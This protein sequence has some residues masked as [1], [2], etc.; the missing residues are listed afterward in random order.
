MSCKLIYKGQEFD[1]P[2]Q[3]LDYAQE[4]R[5]EE[6]TSVLPLPL[7]V[8]DD[9]YLQKE[10]QA[11]M[12]TDKEI[13]QKIE[14]F[15][16]KIGVSV[17]SVREIRDSEGKRINAIAKAD[18]LH[19][20]IEV[21]EDRADITTLPEEAAH[22]FVEMLGQDHPLLKEMMGKITGY[23]LYPDIVAQYK[24]QK[25]YRNDDG[26][27]NFDKLKK[28]AIGKL[29]AQHIIQQERGSETETKLTTAMTWFHKL[30][31]FLKN[32]FSKAKVQDN[33][34]NEIAEKIRTQ[35][36]EDL[37]TSNLKQEGEFYQLDQS[38]EKLNTDQSRIHLDNSIDPVSGQKRH[39]YTYDGVQAKGSV[40]S[41]Y[42]DAWSKKRFRSDNRSEQQKLIDL[43]KAEYGDVIHAEM[44]NIVKSWTNEDGTLRD[45]QAPHAVLS[46]KE[47]YDK[48]SRF[49]LELMN[50]YP[51][52]TI[53]KSETKV[54][55]KKTR[56][57]GSID[58][59][60]IQPDGKV[61]MYDWKSQE[62]SKGQ[63]DLKHY[64]TEM[65][66]I[67]LENY[68]KIL[69]L[70]YGFKD[71]GKIR[72]IP[73]RTAFIYDKGQ[74]AG[75]KEIEIG[76]VDPSLIPED[77]NYL[78]PVT[79]KNESTG[80]EEVDEMIEK[81]H[82]IYDKIA[83]HRYSKDE[84]YKKREEMAKLGS[85]IRDLQLRGTVDK[86]VELGLIEFNKYNEK[87]KS[88]TLTGKDIMEAEKILQVFNDS[89]TYLYDMMQE[90]H[91]SAKESEEPGA[92]QAYEDL[93][94]KFLSMTARTG[95]LISD[96]AK[97]RD[98]E[99]QKLA[100]SNGI[101]NLLDAEKPVGPI[102]GLFAALSKIT[103][104]S[105]RTF[106]K[107]LQRVQ[108]T[109]DAKFD[110]MGEELSGLKKTMEDWAA[111]KGIS[112]SKA[113][114]MMLNTKDGNWNGNF[115]SVYRSEFYKQKEQAIKK[116][117]VD[118]MIKNLVFDD[119]RYEEQEKK[120]L[121]FLKSMQYH[122]DEQKNEETIK[123]KFA[124]WKLYNN[125]VDPKGGINQV[126]LL[127]PANKFLKPKEDW[128]TDQWRELQKPENKPVKDVYDY[129]Q[130]MTRY[131]EGLGMLDEYSPGFIPSIGATKIDQL[132]FGD[133]KDL[134]STKGL[135]ENLEVDSGTKYTPEI[136]PT[137]G[138]VINRI[139]VYF[140]RDMGVEQED[141]TYDY[142]KKS[143]DLFKVFGI[144]GAHMYNYEA[145]QNI[146]DAAMV[147]LEAER[148]KKSLVTDRF[149]NVIM[150]NGKVKAA[151]NNDRNARLL[152][153]FVNFY[154]Y[155]KVNGLG[156]D[157]KFKVPFSDKEYSLTKTV[158]KAIH[159]FSFKTLALNPISGT[160]Q[161]VGGTGN[162]LFMA[163]KG[164]FFTS[165]DWAKAMYQYS[166]RDKK[167][168]AA[169]HWFNPHLEGNQRH[170]IDG[171][172]ISSGNRILS[173][174]KA[175]FIQ[176]KADEAVQNPVAIAMMNNHMIEDGKIV[177]ITQYVKS[178]YNYN[179]T[180]YRMSAQERKDIQQKI[181]KEVGELKETRSLLKVG[182][183]DDHG[184]FSLPGI[185]KDSEA[186]SEFRNKIKGV[187]KKIIGNV[188]RDDINH[189]R[190][191]M[192]GMS[193]MQFRN[194]IPDMVEERLAGLK[195][196]DSLGT[197]TYG[198]MNLFFSEVFSKRFPAL[199][200]S[201]ITGFG[202]DAIK[203]ALQKYEELKRSA[204]EKGEDFNIS[205]GEFIDM[206][207]GNIRSQ[208]LELMTV[209]GFTAGVLAMAGGGGSSND[210]LKG[211]KKYAKRA[212]AK[213]YNEFAFYYNPLEF[214]N[215]VKSPLPVVGLAEDFYRFSG[216][217]AKQ[218]YG[219]A[220][221]NDKMMKSAQPSKYFFRMFPVTKEAML[222]MAAYDDQFRKDWNIKLD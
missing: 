24:G 47:T 129:F 155:D 35:N 159:F 205:E 161:F 51:P 49:V 211:A 145:M 26:T 57:A 181:D 158:T 70:E 94:N 19:K 102:N 153:D 78:L 121:E 42:V 97:Y 29:I 120:Q 108:N 192:L 5:I 28:E 207:I 61:D 107:M 99:A 85:A 13:N 134:F 186:V 91:S 182:T 213:Y 112:M 138:S 123:Q 71:F 170:I 152:E 200:K 23:K 150:E 177:D 171:L 14:S 12:P 172:S 142:S 92:L 140:T 221:S 88:G 40:T 44:E 25:A 41:V 43:T 180:F 144:W 169:I 63:D 217:M 46:N 168:S 84:L 90:L 209:I 185:D 80:N 137:D 16:E 72:A 118:W 199:A 93:K 67:Q 122:L 116:G 18:M 139:P 210:Q 128:Q 148:N 143:R 101:E 124:E 27:V 37:L 115:L 4:N 114:E 111:K 188:N 109:R 127:N 103:Q 54:Y 52:G 164:I 157:V 204:L 183:V 165:G 100:Q 119:V 82:G 174:D 214:T 156:S 62:I 95:K 173:E 89:G 17:H 147:L 189:I 149:G 45:V 31:D 113:F 74:I 3:L 2:D 53:F 136:D 106:S 22:F 212:L 50:Q 60:A 38:L 117:D 141:G 154:L 32:L 83:T 96:I 187:Y 59:L 9:T 132:V 146:E 222:M 179:E 1:S 160:S 39:V 193:L 219:F 176:R 202:D 65:Y 81:L 11:P 220:T 178:K 126:A 21:V 184:H 203:G 10:T 79:L 216:A 56:V 196:D 197:Y 162:A 151:N 133:I 195:Y 58:F 87:I 175:F 34:F 201:I 198:K 135:F 131:A 215:L 73:I 68:R 208:M 104:K 163:K 7:P 130:K 64:K 15:L 66:R 75:L 55:D 218:G 194:W 190:T 30:L 191:T 86:L 98:R 76:T 36:T 77:K 105:F 6:I 69:E 206:Y 20:V 166:S 125:V 48:L 33:P 8:R 167:A 110:K